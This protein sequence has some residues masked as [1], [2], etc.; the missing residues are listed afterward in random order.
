MSFC[1]Y[2]LSSC[3]KTVT[4]KPLVITGLPRSGLIFGTLLIV[5]YH[6]SQQL[7]TASQVPFLKVPK[8]T[9]EVI[10]DDALKALLS[11]PPDT[12]IGRRDKLIL[13]LLYDSAVRVSEL[14][15]MN[16]SSVNLEISIP[17]LRFKLK[18]NAYIFLFYRES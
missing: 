3:I 17:Y 5:T 2:T 15:S 7:F 8:L 16:V 4:A 11:A 1:Y 13:I 6:Y 9:R 18:N 14:L 10:P 12:K